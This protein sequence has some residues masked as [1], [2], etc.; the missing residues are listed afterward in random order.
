M[1]PERDAAGHGK[2]CKPRSTHLDSTFRT[3]HQG[4]WPPTFSRSRCLLS[5]RRRSLGSVGRGYRSTDK[6][7]CS[8]A[9]GT[10]RWRMGTWFDFGSTYKYHC[11]LAFAPNKSRSLRHFSRTA[12]SRHAG[13]ICSRSRAR[14]SA[15]NLSRAIEYLGAVNAVRLR[16]LSFQPVSQSLAAWS[17]TAEV[18]RTFESNVLRTRYRPWC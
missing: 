1:R 6:I 13:C 5:A 10:R 4:W 14:S 17:R 11:R 9:T 2:C 7:V 12:S 3:P 8:G 15:G 16:R 18:G